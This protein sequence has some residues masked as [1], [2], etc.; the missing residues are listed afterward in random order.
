MIIW[1]VYCGRPHYCMQIFT[2]FPERDI[3]LCLSNIE[4]A[5]QLALLN[6]I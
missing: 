4:L 2:F 1:G 5:M 6:G 3:L